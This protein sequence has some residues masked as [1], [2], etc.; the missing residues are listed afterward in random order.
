MWR[1]SEGV[2]AIWTLAPEWGRAEFCSLATGSDVTLADISS[3]LL[4]FTSWRFGRRSLPATY[5]DLKTSPLTRHAFDFV[6]AMDVL[7][8][9]STR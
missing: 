8:T 7:N 1:E 3:T 6:T 2:D 5:I 9:W 4:Q